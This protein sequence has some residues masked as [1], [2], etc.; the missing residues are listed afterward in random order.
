MH[1][2]GIGRMMPTLGHRSGRWLGRRMSSW[3]VRA[4]KTNVVGEVA[5]GR[6]WTTETPV[7]RSQS[8]FGGA[9]ASSRGALAAFVHW[10]CCLQLA[11]LV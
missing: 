10:L 1:S 8:L 7:E 3:L 11:H 4:A 5:A 6:P 2:H 9:V